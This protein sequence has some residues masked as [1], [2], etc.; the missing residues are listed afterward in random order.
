MSDIIEGI[1]ETAAQEPE[2]SSADVA[3]AAPETSNE[4][5]GDAAPEASSDDLVE[6]A[7]VALNTP[8]FPPLLDAAD[9][10]STVPLT[11][12]YDVSVTV[13]VE[14]GRVQLPLGR[15]LQLGEGAVVE[16]DREVTDP[17]DLLAQGVRL[18][19]GEV[20]VVNDQYA[21]RI[22]ELEAVPGGATAARISAPTRSSAET[23]DT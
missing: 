4:D 7:P 15:L 23:A 3:D 10:R 12:F 5:A 20:V 6:D 22:T 19:R 1:D 17:V 13:S 16:L 8:D 11:R 2:A 21:V 9:E 18:G 14:L